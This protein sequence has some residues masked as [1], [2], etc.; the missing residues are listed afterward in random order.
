MSVDYPL[1]RRIPPPNRPPPP[2]PRPR[3]LPRHAEE[4]VRLTKAGVAEDEAHG[5][6]HLEGIPHEHLRQEHEEHARRHSDAMELGPDSEA[7]ARE[8]KA[9]KE[10][11][12]AEAQ[13]GDQDNQHNRETVKQTQRSTG[14]STKPEDQGVT[15][16]LGNLKKKDEFQNSLFRT[17]KK[18][19]GADKLNASRLAP[20][21]A[22]N[23]AAQTS[24]A[25][26]EAAERAMKSGKPP[27]AFA[28][29]NQS[30]PHGVFFKE[31]SEREGDGAEEDPELAAAV[32]ETL[33]LLFGVRGIIRVGPGR[34]QADEPVIV[35]VVGQGFGE[36]QLK[37]IPEK[38]G[39]FPTLLAVP[40]E[41]LPLKRER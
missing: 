26:R 7:E 12:L 4:K 24:E 15:D 21:E 3:R 28:L 9:E 38:V 29:L 33:R 36:A 14:D 6:E 39:R 2:P 10:E 25:A 11:S 1:V 16:T 30:Q 19:L 23:A 35:I 22:A 37:V 31:D 13:R 34:N 5:A 17:P 18:D 32:D 27:D 20:T 8:K 41:V 40:F